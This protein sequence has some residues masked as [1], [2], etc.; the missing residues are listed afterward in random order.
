MSLLKGSHQIPH[1]FPVATWN[2]TSLNVS[3]S[4]HSCQAR[5][6]LNHLGRPYVHTLTCS[7]WAWSLHQHIPETSMWTKELP[8]AFRLLNSK[9]YEHIG[10]Q[11]PVQSLQNSK[12]FIFAILCTCYKNILTC[13]LCNPWDLG[14]FF[15]RQ[16]VETM[17]TYFPEPISII[18]ITIEWHAYIHQIYYWQFT[19]LISL[20]MPYKTGIANISIL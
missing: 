12:S 16:L 14:L 18:V 20:Y 11:P 1:S 7:T 13:V 9:A 19:C 6:T 5:R 17:I 4:W 3:S 8:E 15:M 10:H 2:D